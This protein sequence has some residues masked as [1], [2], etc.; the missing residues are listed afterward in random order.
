MTVE[1]SN[2]AKR[3]V[4]AGRAPPPVADPAWIDQVQALHELVP[5]AKA[6][7][8]K[9]VW[10]YLTGGTETESTLRR[11]RRAI[12]ELALVPRML[13]DVSWIDPSRSLFGRDLTMPVIL[14]PVGSLE[15]F[16]PEG[17]AAA[18]RAA[19]RAGVMMCLSSVSGPGLEAT[20]EAAPAARIFQLYVRGDEAWIDDH[21]SRAIDAGYDAFCV[22][23]DVALY[24]RRE[25]DVVN[26]FDKPWRRRATGGNFQAGLTWDIVAGI[27]ARHDIPLLIKGIMTP[28]DALKALDIGLEGIWVSNHGGRQ[29]DHAPG[30]VAVLPEIVEAVG[31][32]A[33]VV[34]DGGFWR[35]TDLL[36]ALALGADA[37]ALGR[38][39][40]LALGAGGEE[41]L[42]RALDLLLEEFWTAMGLMGLTSLDE[43]GPGAVTRAPA[44]T[45]ARVF[46]AFPLLDPELLKT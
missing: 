11:N 14:A 6:R 38:F 32:R 39:N 26:R 13:R 3:Q 21:V 28:D 7:L 43:L 4:E 15:S 31:G 17:G 27:K 25:R 45:E 8:S 19:H 33:K 35:G 20:A 24:S 22:T 34:V 36:K 2:S 40:A 37:V 41:A 44:T 42:V 9:D 30:A 23:V 1:K 16:D 5:L 46:S 10:G 18:A 12:D 29:L